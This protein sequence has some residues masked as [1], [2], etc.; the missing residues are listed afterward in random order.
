MLCKSLQFHGFETIRHLHAVHGGIVR[1]G[2]E[3]AFASMVFEEGHIAPK[4]SG[5]NCIPYLGH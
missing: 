2:V 3:G 5:E 4:G 1:V